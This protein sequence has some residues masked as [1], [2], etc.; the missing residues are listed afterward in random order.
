[1]RRP[2]DAMSREKMRIVYDRSAKSAAWFGRRLV[3][4]RRKSTGLMTEPTAKT[5]KARKALTDLGKLA[6]KRYPT[7]GLAA[8]ALDIAID[9]AVTAYD[10]C[11]IALARCSSCSPGRHLHPLARSASAGVRETFR[12]VDPKRTYS[13]VGSYHGFGLG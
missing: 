4:M 3:T 1:M 2:S 6:L 9:K 11:Y 8:Q 7:A 5:E 12:P 13:M 10:A